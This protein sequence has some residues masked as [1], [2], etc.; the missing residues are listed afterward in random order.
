MDAKSAAPQP[1]RV[2]LATNLLWGFLALGAVFLGIEFDY[3][4]SDNPIIVAGELARVLGLVAIGVLIYYVSRGRNL[5][6]AM[7]L[8]LT[9]TGSLFLIFH[10]AM[11]FSHSTFAGV[12]SVI[13]VLM[14][15]VALY[16]LYSKPGDEFFRD[17]PV[18]PAAGAAAPVAVGKDTSSLV[19]GGVSSW[20]VA[21]SWLGLGT[22]LFILPGPFAL[23]AGFMA[24]RDIK[25]NPALR[26]AGRADFGIWMGILGTTIMGFIATVVFM[27]D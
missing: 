11:Q 15:P 17:K 5:A 13:Q 19:P 18:A 10:V 23:V 1:R 8:S 24:Q 3:A 20:A 9:A 21:A 25:K 14:L 6:R 4:G 22:L 2:R 26:G 7:I 16:F 12:V 27:S